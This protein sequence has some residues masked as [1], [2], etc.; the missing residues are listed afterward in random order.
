MKIRLRRRPSSPR[1]ADTT[2]WYAPDSVSPL[3]ASMMA[4]MP[5]GTANVAFQCCVAHSPARG[6]VGIHAGTASPALFTAIAHAVHCFSSSTAYL[7][8]KTIGT[9][10]SAT[11]AASDSAAASVFLPPVER[12]SFE[13]SGQLAKPMTSAPSTGTRKPWKK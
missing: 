1:P 3:T 5:P 13:C 12:T 10:K 2:R 8:A 6:R 9:T 11:T 4:L 7:D